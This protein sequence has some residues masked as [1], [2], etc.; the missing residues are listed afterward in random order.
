MELWRDETCHS[1]FQ[2]AGYTSKTLFLNGKSTKTEG[3]SVK[4]SVC[5]VPLPLIEITIRG[6]W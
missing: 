4:E 3:K 2:A 6:N 5:R 1:T